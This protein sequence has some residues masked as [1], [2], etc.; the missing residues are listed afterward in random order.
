MFV[1]KASKTRGF[2]M[3][4]VSKVKQQE[5]ATRASQSNRQR[6]RSNA[7]KET[8]DTSRI[9]MD[10]ITPR[11]PHPPPPPPSPPAPPIPPRPPH[12]PPPP[13]PIPPPPPGRTELKDKCKSK[14][15]CAES[16]E[17]AKY[18]KDRYE[19]RHTHTGKHRTK[20]MRNGELS[21][22]LYSAARRLFCVLL[23][24]TPPKPM[25]KQNA[26][27][28]SGEQSAKTRVSAHASKEIAPPRAA[29][30]ALAANNNNTSSNNGNS[31]NINTAA[32]CSCY[33]HCYSVVTSR[34]SS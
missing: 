18:C 1:W 31:S 28:I 7:T 14:P 21:M 29:A 27:S 2:C 11:P 8:E 25:R 3:L 20:T 30:D 23:Q 6:S 34:P 10:V 17:S 15:A 5:A 13:P 19:M 16:R 33:R 9:R 12:P 26:S 32:S 4:D 24:K 22:F